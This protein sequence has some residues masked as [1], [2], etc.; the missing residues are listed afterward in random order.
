MVAY[1]FGMHNNVNLNEKVGH[2]HT[3]ARVRARTHTHT[4]SL[5]WMHADTNS[6]ADTDTLR[7]SFTTLTDTWRDHKSQDDTKLDV[8]ATET[9]SVVVNLHVHGRSPSSSPPPFLYGLASLLEE[10]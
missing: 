4:H 1:R 5:S 6:S 2:T 9:H 10:K 7:S 3:R 8:V